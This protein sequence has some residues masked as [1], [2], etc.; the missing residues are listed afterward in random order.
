LKAL[1]H[2]CNAA[3]MRPARPTNFCCI[4]SPSLQ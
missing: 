3:A 4:Y 1:A 2:C